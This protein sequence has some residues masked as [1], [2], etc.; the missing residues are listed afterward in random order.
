MQVRSMFGDVGTVLV[1]P[2]P[3]KG[4]YLVQLQDGTK[5][6]WTR[7]NCTPVREPRKKKLPPDYGELADMVDAMSQEQIQSLLRRL[8]NG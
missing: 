7:D 2:R 3:L 1:P 4:T 6:L 8:S 5:E